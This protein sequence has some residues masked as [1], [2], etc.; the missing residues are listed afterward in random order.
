MYWMGAYLRNFSDIS[1]DPTA[2]WGTFVGGNGVWFVIPLLLILI[3]GIKLTP[4]EV[5]TAVPLKKKVE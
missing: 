4:V 1:S 5:V 3:S 2:F